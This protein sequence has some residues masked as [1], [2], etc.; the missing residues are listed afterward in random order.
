MR[1]SAS[2]FVVSNAVS[3]TW[4]S[5]GIYPPRGPDRRF[6]ALRR[7][8]SESALGIPNCQICAITLWF[9]RS[10]DGVV[11]GVHGR[12]PGCSLG[13]EGVDHRADG[14]TAG[15][16]GA[17][18]RG[19]GRTAPTAPSC[20]VSSTSAAWVSSRRGGDLQC[21][22]AVGKAGSARP[23]RSRSR[24]RSGAKFSGGAGGWAQLVAAEGTHLLQRSRQ[25][26]CIAAM[27]IT[28]GTDW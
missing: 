9:M 2:P 5:T 14:E 20:R 10:R 6:S 27:T 11:L 17:A 19:V 23:G 15:A 26:P 12:I 3:D 22:T 13:E 18:F 1:K 24:S 16:A 25:T 21:H 4:L 28:H 8:R 7:M